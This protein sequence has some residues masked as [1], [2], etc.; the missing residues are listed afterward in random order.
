MRLVQPA[1]RH[2]LWSGTEA[3]SGA[4]GG[5]MMLMRC[6]AG[7]AGARS[8]PPLPPLAQSSIKWILRRRRG[9]A[10]PYSSVTGGGH[11]DVTPSARPRFSDNFNPYKVHANRAT[12]LDTQNI[13]LGPFYG[14]MAVPSVTRCRCC[15]WRCRRGHRCVRQRHLVNG[16]AAARSGEWAQH[17]SNAS[18]F[19]IDRVAGEIYVWWRPCMCVCVSV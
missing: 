3:E 7:G 18:C 12:V 2:S 16:R 15:R 1:L 11:V 14:A 17:F 4:D 6:R 8:S 19:I 10:A 9:G 5:M 13:F